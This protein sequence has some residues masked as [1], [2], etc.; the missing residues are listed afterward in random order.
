MRNCNEKHQNDLLSFKKDFL[1]LLLNSLTKPIRW[2]SEF[3]C[4]QLQYIT[5]VYWFCTLTY[6]QWQ[7]LRQKSHWNALHWDVRTMPQL[8]TL[9]RLMCNS[10]LWCERAAS[11]STA[12][13]SLG[14]TPD[15]QKSL[16]RFQV[17]YGNFSPKLKV[18]QYIFK[19][20]TKL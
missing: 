19:I 8:S 14:S 4:K 9:R 7:S 12:S 17:Y 1:F 6:L 16:F 15:T 20:H 10:L 18:S 13:G 11:H 5:A 3:S 2:Y